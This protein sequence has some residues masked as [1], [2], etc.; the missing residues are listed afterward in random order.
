MT[1]MKDQKNTRKQGFQ[2][3]MVENV[4]EYIKNCQDCQQQGKCFYKDF[5]VKYTNIL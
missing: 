2:Q 3:L 4:K 1:Y 5:F